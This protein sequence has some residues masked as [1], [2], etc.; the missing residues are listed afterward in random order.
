MILF[1][2]LFGLLRVDFRLC[3]EFSQV[4]VILFLPDLS[5]YFLASVLFELLRVDVL[6]VGLRFVCVVLS[7]VVFCE[8]LDRDSIVVVLEDYFCYLWCLFI[9]AQ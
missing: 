5:H 6:F 1:H 7:E 8:L 9:H 4:V 2:D 3:N